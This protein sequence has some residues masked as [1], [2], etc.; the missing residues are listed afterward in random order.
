MDE[1]S[2][3]HQEIIIDDL[4]TAEVQVLINEFRAAPSHAERLMPPILS[5]NQS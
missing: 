2:E 4:Q 1:A 5:T 3:M